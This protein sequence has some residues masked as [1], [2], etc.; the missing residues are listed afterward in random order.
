MHGLPGGLK[1]CGD[2]INLFAIFTSEDGK[3]L[4]SH[5]NV[6]IFYSSVVSCR[7]VPQGCGGW[8]VHVGRYADPHHLIL[9]DTLDIKSAGKSVVNYTDQ[10]KF[11]MY[12][13]HVISIITIFD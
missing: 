10:I 12:V 8:E 11:V 4:L 13:L 5:F 9:S 3:Q 6:T 7:N 1:L 2:L